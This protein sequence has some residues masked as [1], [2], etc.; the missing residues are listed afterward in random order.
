MGENRADCQPQSVCNFVRFTRV[1]VLL[2]SLCLN[3]HQAGVLI[4]LC[5]IRRD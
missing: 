4:A 3:S 2:F 1:M 5:P